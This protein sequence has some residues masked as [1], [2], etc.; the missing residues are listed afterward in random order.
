VCRRVFLFQILLG[1]FV[2]GAA[3]SAHFLDQAILM[4]SV[5]PLDTPFGL[6]RTGRDNAN[7]QLLT[8]APKL[9]HRN[10]SSP[11]LGCARRTYVHI[12]PIGIEGPRHSVLLDPAS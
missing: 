11:L 1:S 7:A 12:L 4:S 10:F 3:F 9:R 2:A 8:H 5:I 6:G